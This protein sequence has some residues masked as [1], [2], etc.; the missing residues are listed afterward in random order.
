[1]V[2]TRKK[3]Q[4]NKRLRSQLN[5]FDQDIIIGNAMGDRQENAT[6]N[7]GTVDQGFTAGNS[8]SN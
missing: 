6:F 2:S 1:M 7:E 3:R 4:S 8:D 5:Y